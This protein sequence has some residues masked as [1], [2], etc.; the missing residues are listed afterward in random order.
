[1]ERWLKQTSTLCECDELASRLE[2]RLR[3]QSAEL[4]QFCFDE[5]T[6]EYWQTQTDLAKEKADLE[7]RVKMLESKQVSGGDMDDI[8]V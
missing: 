2:Q 1:M 3:E 5:D 6:E 4:D 8:Q 7:E